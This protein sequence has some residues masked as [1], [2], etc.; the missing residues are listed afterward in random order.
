[1]LERKPTLAAGDVTLLI[2]D[3]DDVDCYNVVR[4]IKALG[5]TNTTLRARD[6]VEALAMLRAP[7]SVRRPCVVL[8][9]INMPRMNGFEMLMALRD[10]AALSSTVVFMM[11]TSRSEDDILQAY[12][13]NVAG[14]IAKSNAKEGARCMF[15]MLNEYLNTVSFPQSATP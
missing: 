6:G 5:M 8:L 2:V 14:F 11:T 7:G 15:S 3:D 10:D 13:H 1:M 12:K 4:S 9:D